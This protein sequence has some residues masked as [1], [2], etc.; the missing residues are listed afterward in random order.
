VSDREDDLSFDP[1]R[2]SLRPATPIGQPP[3]AASPDPRRAGPGIARVAVP[4]AILLA[5]ALAAWSARPDA[6]S[7]TPSPSVA[8][9]EVPRAEGASRRTLILASAGEIEATLLAAG[10]APDQAAAAA[11]SARAALGTAPGDVRLVFDLGAA[12]GGA[13]LAMME[14]TRNDGSGVALTRAAD[15]RIAERRTAARLTTR[16]EIVRGELDAESF[17]SSAVAAGVND[18]L[19]GAFAN[20]FSFDFDMQQEVGPGDVFEA[21]FEQR[22]NPSGEP[23]G[24]PVLVY[25]SLATPAKTRALYRHAA[26][27]EAE[28][29][30]FDSNGRSTRR[31]LL[32]TPVDSARISSRFGPRSHPI[33]GFVKM[34][35][36]TDFAAPTGTPIFAAGDAVVDFAGPRG[37]NG[38]FVRLRHDNGWTTLYLHMNRIWPAITPGARVAQGQQIGEVGTTGR[39][40]GPHLHYEV[41]VESGAVD[42]LSIDTGT[43]KS[44]AGPGLAAFRERRDRVD[45]RRARAG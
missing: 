24:A 19:I 27:G 37:A 1:R 11:R 45:A 22:Y 31:A 41:H 18:R 7:P 10:A 9:P 13:A 39:S 14:A 26:P 8:A 29:G 20:A 3:P 43:G 28:P 40:T 17:Y 21:G 30:W 5:G 38:N 23:V 33:L 15:G 35:R 36:G 34:H 42:P 12:P 32:R 2:W 6:A 4:A 16:L 25:A 44:L